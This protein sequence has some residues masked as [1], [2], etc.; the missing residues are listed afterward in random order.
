[1]EIKQKHTLLVLAFALTLFSACDKEDKN[2]RKTAGLYDLEKYEVKYYTSGNLDST[3]NSENL[4]TI[5]LYDNDSRIYNNTTDNWPGYPKGWID[6][7]LGG[8]IGWYPDEGKNKTL[9]FFSED[10]NGFI[11]YAIYNVEKT[12]RN[13]FTW[14][15]V[16]TDVN[17]AF[18]YVEK[19]FMKKQ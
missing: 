16:A 5:G 18:L 8:A 9:T 4:G 10:A 1:V 7:G 17:G 2:R 3:Y 14:T 11:A 12:G 6:N 15:Y 19:L 13:K